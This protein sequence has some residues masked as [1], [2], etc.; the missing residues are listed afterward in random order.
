MQPQLR[1][2]RRPVCWTL[3]LFHLFLSLPPSYQVI[4]S[5]NPPFT[6]SLPNWLL[7]NLFFLAPFTR[8]LRHPLF[9]LRID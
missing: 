5:E 8:L 7:Q 9:A 1:D 3:D 4:D 2:L 6:K